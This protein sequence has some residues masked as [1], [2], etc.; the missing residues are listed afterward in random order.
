MSRFRVLN[1]Y[2]IY[3][4]MATRIFSGVHF[5]LRKLIF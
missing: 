2:Y 3:T 5:F 1:G 4:E